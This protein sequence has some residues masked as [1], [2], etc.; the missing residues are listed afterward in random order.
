MTENNIKNTVDSF[1]KQSPNRVKQENQKT[2]NTSS[3]DKSEMTAP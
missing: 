2:P 1:I 3:Q